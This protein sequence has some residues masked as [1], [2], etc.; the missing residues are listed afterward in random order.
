MKISCVRKCKLCG[1]VLKHGRLPYRVREGG[2]SLH[3]TCKRN[4]DRREGGKPSFDARDMA[5]VSK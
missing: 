5:R 2:F 1:G 3:R 4:L